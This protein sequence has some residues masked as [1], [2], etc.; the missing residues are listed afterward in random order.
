MDYGLFPPEITSSRMYSGPGAGSMLAAAAAWDEMAT[1]LGAAA[2]SYSSVI[3]GLSG[4]SWQGPSSASMAAAAAPYI[5]WLNTTAAQVEQAA[6]QIKAAVGAYETAFAMTVPPSLIAAN[7]AELTT[8]IATNVVGQNAPAIAATEAQYGEMWARD[9]AAMYGYAGSSAAASKVTA[10]SAPPL[11]T[12]P[13]GVTSH[14]AAAAQTVGSSAGAQADTVLSTMPQLIATV[15]PAL[16]GLASPSSTSSTSA[17]SALTPSLSQLSALTM[18]ARFATYPLNFV[19]RAM[20]MAKGVATPGAAAVTGVKAT[21]TGVSAGLAATAGVPAPAGLPNL[22]PAVVASA[23]MGR[24]V[25]LGPLS[26]PHGWATGVLAGADGIPA[27]AGSQLA[28]MGSATGVG[29]ATGASAAV[30]PVLPI[31]NMAG[32][33]FGAQASQ[34][35]LRPTVIPRSPSAG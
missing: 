11:M 13:A 9:A 1:E 14:T 8:L 27:G 18:P 30:P 35:D 7:R 17:L 23:E 28:A 24:A 29:P 34:Y 33:G 4:A 12:D 6:S 2:V 16:Q 20:T 26:V 10:F 25:S 22:S 19:Q 5:A 32:R 15:P 3:S 21:G 31:T